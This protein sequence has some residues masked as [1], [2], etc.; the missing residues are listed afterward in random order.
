[1][2]LDKHRVDKLV[3]DKKDIE[4]E[5][6]NIQLNC[7]HADTILK[8]NHSEVR[9]QCKTCQASLAYA[10]ASELEKFFKRD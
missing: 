3:S 7:S 2:E 1:M 5:L 4:K 6:S 8:Q 10:S 9:W